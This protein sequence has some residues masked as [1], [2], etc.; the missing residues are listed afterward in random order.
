ME[1]NQ[2][3]LNLT[4]KTNLLQKFNNRV[5]FSSKACIIKRDLLC[6]K[7]DPICEALEGETAI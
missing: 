4:V 1:W 2:Y 5:S 7:K 6:Q 3:N